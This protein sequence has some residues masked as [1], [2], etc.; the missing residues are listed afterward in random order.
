M[1]LT[2]LFSHNYTWCVRGEQDHNHSS[3]EEL[4]HFCLL[5]VRTSIKPRLFKYMPLMGAQSESQDGEREG[6][7]ATNDGRR[8]WVCA[9]ETYT[10]R[11]AQERSRS[12]IGEVGEK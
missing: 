6:S 3:T 7:M 2:A 5:F 10:V 9:F 1:D 4:C 11:D 8:G 12:D